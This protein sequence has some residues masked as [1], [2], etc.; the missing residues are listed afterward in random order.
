MKQLTIA[1]MESEKSEIMTFEELKAEAK[2]QG[3]NLMPIHKRPKLLPCTCGCNRRG[4]LSKY[5]DGVWH[6]GLRCKR[7]GKTAWGIGETE[8]IEAWNEIILKEQEHE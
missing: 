1:V 8:V 2:R 4:H 5:E 6:D 3:Y 7:C